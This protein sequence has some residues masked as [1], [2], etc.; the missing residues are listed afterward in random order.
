MISDTVTV[1]AGAAWGSASFNL[2]RFYGVNAHVLKAVTP[3]SGGLNGLSMVKV[4]NYNVGVPS[5]WPGPPP[6]QN[7]PVPAGA[8]A[9]VCF[10]PPPAQLLAGQLDGQL[11]A[12]LS[13]AAPGSWLTAN[14]EANDPS[15]QFWS[16]PGVSKP[17]DLQNVH[18]YLRDFC[19]KWAPQVVYG[20]DFGSSPIYGAGQDCTQYT[21]PGLGFYSFDAYDR[22]TQN[23]SGQW[24][25]KFTAAQVFA[26][27]DQIR[28]KFPDANLAVTETNT[29]RVTLDPESAGQWF[30]DVATVAENH[31]CIAYL[32]WWGPPGTSNPDWQK[33]EFTAGAPYVAALNQIAGQFS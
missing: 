32:T 3:A 8:N 14:Q 30:L 28:A 19:A 22:P 33:I 25:S 7:Q 26:G 11:R 20:Q 6:G 9:L 10:L 23:A 2:A 1:K 4:F 12:F 5:S 27:M 29:Q 24:V 15:N 21:V 13:G 31:G 16:Q 18:G 17:S